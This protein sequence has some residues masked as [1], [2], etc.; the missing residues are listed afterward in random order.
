VSFVVTRS[1]EKFDGDVVE[2]GAGYRIH[3]Q[4]EEL[5]RDRRHDGLLTVIGRPQPR[6]SQATQFERAGGPC[7]LSGLDGSFAAVFVQPA[8]GA[9]FVGTDRLGSR[10]I[11]TRTGPA[12]AAASNPALLVEPGHRVDRIALCALLAFGHLPGPRT[13]FEGVRRVP[14]GAWLRVDDGTVQRHWAFPDDDGEASAGDV[15]GTLARFEDAAVERSRAASSSPVTLLLSGG[16]DSRALWHRLARAGIPMDVIT[17]GPDTSGD[18]I[19]ARA[20]TAGTG[21]G[22]RVVP[23]TFGDAV[24][25]LLAWSRV[26]ADPSENLFATLP[27]GPRGLCDLPGTSLWLGTHGWEP[28]VVEAPPDPAE[29]GDHDD[30]LAWWIVRRVVARKTLPIERLVNAGLIPTLGSAAGAAIAEMLEQARPR[31]TE[32]LSACLERV[33]LEHRFVLWNLNRA[34]FASLR[35]DIVTPFHDVDLVEMHRRLPVAWRTER[36]AHRAAN[37]DRPGEPAASSHGIPVDYVR[38]LDAA[39]LRR[40]MR[41]LI[42]GEPRL[43]ELVPAATVDLLADLDDAAPRLVFLRLTLAAAALHSSRGVRCS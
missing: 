5:Q 31:P 4:D 13:L 17:F 6:S 19:A 22:H 42:V 8:T 12:P 2:L 10:L 1:G 26:V 38:A 24:A 40:A 3:A 41:E 11:Y 23:V 21:I 9:C 28:H 14:P 35:R 27:M 25:A 15:A 32:S 16:L 30:A 29:L 7:P 43:L 37:P 39:D 20:L 36:R 33:S 34:M 18:V